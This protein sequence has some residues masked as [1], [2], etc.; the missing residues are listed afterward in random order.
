MCFSVDQLCE[1]FDESHLLISIAKCTFSG[2]QKY[3]AGRE[4]RT[5]LAMGMGNIISASQGVYSS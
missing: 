5:R 3:S 1:K 4:V 2:D